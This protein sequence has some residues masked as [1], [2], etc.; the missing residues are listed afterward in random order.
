VET[1][2]DAR[3]PSLREILETIVA[4]ALCFGVGWITHN[5][6]IGAGL[7]VLLCGFVIARWVWVGRYR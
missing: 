7:L 3:R 1:G 2:Q 4:L 6:W 5:D